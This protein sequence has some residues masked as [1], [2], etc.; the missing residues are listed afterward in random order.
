MGNIVSLEEGAEG[1]GGFKAVH[2]V[3]HRIAAQ[4]FAVLTCM[5]HEY[6]CGSLQSCVLPSFPFTIL[7][8]ASLG[9]RRPIAPHPPNFLFIP[10]LQ[11]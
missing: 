9:G 3:A 7:R 6:R 1:L 8:P 5:E 4:D 11:C 2:G 10:Q